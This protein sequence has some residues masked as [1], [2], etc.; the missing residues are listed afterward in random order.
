M[1]AILERN[2]IRVDRLDAVLDFGCGCGRV[3]RHWQGVA[4][5]KLVG[6]DY[7][8]KLVDWCE[9]NI[10]FASFGVNALRPPLQYANSG[11]DLAYALSVFTHLP[12]DIQLKWFEE[13]SRV[14]KP[15]GYL[16]LTTLGESYKNRLNHHERQEFDGGNLVVKESRLAGRNACSAYHPL[17]Y[18]ERRLAK[19]YALVEFAAEGALGMPHQDLVLLRSRLS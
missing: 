9:A 11:F 18:I 13:L 3:M 6:T 10:P 5:A 15:G 19:S 17:S 16:L 14:L 4:T 8:S 12:E 7:N 2:G 1:S